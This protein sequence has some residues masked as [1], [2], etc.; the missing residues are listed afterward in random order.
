MEKRLNKC[1]VKILCGLSVLRQ[2]R[3]SSMATHLIDSHI[4]ESERSVEE[5][6]VFLQGVEEGRR[7]AALEREEGQ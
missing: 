5:T 4:E 6:K 2:M 1:V 7:A 3:G